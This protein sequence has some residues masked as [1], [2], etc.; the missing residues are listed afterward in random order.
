V[1]GDEP[2]TSLRQAAEALAYAREQE[3]I[4]WAGWS[5]VLHG[6]AL[7]A[8]GEVDAGV[9]AMRQGI[10]DW[11]GTG[12]RGFAGVFLTFLAEG[13]AKQGARGETLDEAERFAV[14]VGERWWLPEIHRVRGEVLAA[15]P[16]A[17]ERDRAEAKLAA[18]LDA[19]RRI[20]A[21]GFEA[22][23]RASL[24]AVRRQTRRGPIGR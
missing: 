18:A 3:F 14:E 15:S 19:A 24:D 5:G 6:S 23:A 8:G 21:R 22:R 7:V 11:H 4:F 16:E 17:A 9:E 2:G 13:L 1:T 10:T 12:S 20:G